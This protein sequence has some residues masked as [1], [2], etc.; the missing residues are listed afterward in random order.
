MTEPQVDHEPIVV[1]TEAA[2][3]N[4]YWTFGKQEI[5]NIQSTFRGNLSREEIAAHLFSLKESM[6]QVLEI[7]GHA[8]TVGK[9]GDVSTIIMPATPTQAATETGKAIEPPTNG[10]GNAAPQGTMT[11]V[12]HT[13]KVL[14][15]P[16]GKVT[17]EFWQ[18]GRQY[19]EL[20]AKG[21]TL[22]R[23]QKLLSTVSKHDVRMAENLNINCQVAYTLGKEYKPGKHY[24]DVQAIYPA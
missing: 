15:Q 24:E 9:A 10:N 14:P 5:F 18:T 8:K 6:V 3:S 2:S 16:G 17:L 23:A 7:G 1:S 22:E 13:I 19:A 20:Y 12:I 11:K 21:W 4:F